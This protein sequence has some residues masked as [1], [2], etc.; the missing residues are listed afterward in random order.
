[1]PGL[2][3]PAVTRHGEK[4][5]FDT[6]QPIVKHSSL[7]PILDLDSEKATH[8]F[9]MFFLPGIDLR[10]WISDQK[11]RLVCLLILKHLNHDAASAANAHLSESR[12]L[13][14]TA[15]ERHS[16]INPRSP[17]GLV[18]LLSHDLLLIKKLFCVICLL[19]ED[20]WLHW[21]SNGW[22]RT[23]TSG[24]ISPFHF[25]PSDW[26]NQMPFPIA[27]FRGSS[28]PSS[29]RTFWW[30]SFRLSQWFACFRI[31]LYSV[32]SR[33][34]LRQAFCQALPPSKR[35]KHARIG[36]DGSIWSV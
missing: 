3:L 29:T 21:G 11:E 18:E 2:R 16:L 24:L 5:E 23:V 6:P 30:C 9:H 8:Y 19:W 27:R 31:T 14:K 33:L 1:M 13:S 22:I 7:W 20:H 4:L 35:S 32:H 25:A 17:A 10:I 12:R 26:A 15:A 34:Y 28:D 36:V